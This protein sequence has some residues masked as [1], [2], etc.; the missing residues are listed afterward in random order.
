MQEGVQEGVQEDPIYDRILRPK[1]NQYPKAKGYLNLLFI[2]TFNHKS[3]YF[4]TCNIATLLAYFL[5]FLQKIFFYKSLI[6]LI[7]TISL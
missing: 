1:Q 3:I 5:S 6:L 2:S 4:L 7:K